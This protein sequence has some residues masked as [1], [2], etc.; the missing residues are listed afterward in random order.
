MAVTRILLFSLHGLLSYNVKTEISNSPS[1]L[2]KG[3]EQSGKERFA[4]ML[5]QQSANTE[6]HIKATDKTA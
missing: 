2:S 1:I 5:P 4:V 3:H 6:S